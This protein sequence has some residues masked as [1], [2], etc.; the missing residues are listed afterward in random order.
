M[1]HR[2][3][4]VT[5]ASIVGVLLAG[6]TAAA[7]NL[8]ILSTTSDADLG[9]ADPTVAVAPPATSPVRDH[10][11]PA[12]VVEQPELL[13]YEIPGVGVIMV[14]RSG[15]SLSVAQVAT[16][17]WQAAVTTTGPQLAVSFT[18][19][20]RLVEFTSSVIGDRV[21]VDVSEKPASSQ[22]SDDD[23]WYEGADHEDGVHDD[24]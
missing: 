19:G 3:A 16:P 14:E 21:V 13:A 1:K 11:E 17:G 12:A 24:D 2:T 18:D 22:G 4:I 6:A 5:A 23:D 9:S 8:G 7:A 15:S 20:A 10:V